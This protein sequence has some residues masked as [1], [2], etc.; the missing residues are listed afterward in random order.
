MSKRHRDADAIWNGGASNRL[1]VAN[2]LVNAIQECRAEGNYDCHDAATMMI[3]DHLAYLIGLPQPSLDL[4]LAN[5][6]RVEDEVARR[7]DEPAA[8]PASN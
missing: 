2:A 6:K 8:Q 1:A 4:S 3:L 5:W 7:K